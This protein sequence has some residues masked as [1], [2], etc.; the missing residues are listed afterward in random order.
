[1][2]TQTIVLAKDKNHDY[3]EA[4]DNEFNRAQILAVR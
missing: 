2:M 1:M 3:I 4:S